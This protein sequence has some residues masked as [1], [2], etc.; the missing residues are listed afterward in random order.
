MV[1]F[2][3]SL[4]DDLRDW[5]LEQ[6]LFFIATAPRHGKHVNLSPKGLPADTLYFRDPNHVQY[7]DLTGSGAETISH[8]YENGRATLMFCSFSQ[9]PRI[10]RLFCTGRVIE[11][12]HPEFKSLLPRFGKAETPGARSIILLDIW[13]V[14]TSCGFAVPQ[15]SKNI[16]SDEIVE[17][18]DTAP[19][20]IPELADRDTLNNFA[21]KTEAAGKMSE[22]R[23]KNNSRSLDGLPGL[24]IARIDKGERVWLDGMESAYRQLVA[25]RQGILFGFVM[26]L[27]AMFLANLVQGQRGMVFV[28]R[29]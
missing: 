12:T 22:Y 4:S 14:Q 25:Q 17:A 26:A 10:M 5:A 16:S 2:Y 6:Q 19:P 27:V 18:G 13:K 28:V 29:Q 11:Y 24:R 20:V 1:K 9:S 21:I 3:E 7:L 23:A 15:F 8:V